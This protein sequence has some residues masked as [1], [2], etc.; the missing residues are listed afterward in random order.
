MLCHVDL[1]TFVQYIDRNL[2]KLTEYTYNPQEITV[3][4]TLEDKEDKL[5]TTQEIEGEQ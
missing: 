4:P 1:S 5:H 2:D 3:I